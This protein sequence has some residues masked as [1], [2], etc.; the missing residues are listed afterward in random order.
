MNEAS[1]GSVLKAMSRNE[2]DSRLQ[3][4][5]MQGR[6]CGARLR[7]DPIAIASIT[8][9]LLSGGGAILPVSRGIVHFF[10]SIDSIVQFVR[11]CLVES[12]FNC[13]IELLLH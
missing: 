1:M 13:S 11:Y 3:L 10:Y 6:R 4:A 8:A 2:G 5:R 9:I 7:V 12:L